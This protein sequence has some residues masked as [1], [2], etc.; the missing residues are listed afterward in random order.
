ML[1]SR[2][3]TSRTRPSASYEGLEPSGLHAHERA[4]GAVKGLGLQIRNAGEKAQ[5]DDCTKAIKALVE[6]APQLHS[7]V[8]AAGCQK[9]RRRVRGLL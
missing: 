9:R 7:P 8:A 5:V 3:S 4:L 2:A 1:V 6:L